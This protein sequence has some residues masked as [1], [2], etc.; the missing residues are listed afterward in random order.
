MTLYDFELDENCYKV[1]LLLATSG[2]PHEKVSVDVYPGREHKT[3]AI[4]A[5]NPVG[6]LPILDDSQTD[7]PRVILHG[8][9]A[10]LLYLAQGYDAA[11]H[12]MPT[13]PQ[14]FGAV[15]MWLQF[16][17][18]E[19]RPAV[20]A[21]E[22]ALFAGPD[23]TL[24]R[25]ARQSFRIME[26]HMT[27]QGFD[28]RPWFVGDAPSLADIALFPHIALSRDFGV[29]HEAYPALRRWMRRVRRW[30]GFI[31]MPGVPAYA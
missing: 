26:D 29:E 22:A 16:A 7:G 11:R 25:T 19:L 1:R 15:A 20:L 6:S 31:T 24:T 13:E 28:G 14:A 3:P 27:G 8:A 21:R 2:V 23:E 30:E 4:R 9:E 10:I 18:V 17:A 5:L 12:W